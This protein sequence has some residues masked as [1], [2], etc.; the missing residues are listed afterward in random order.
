MKRVDVNSSTNIISYL[1]GEEVVGM[2][3]ETKTN[4]TELRVEKITKRRGDKLYAKWKILI[5][6]MSL[7]PEP[8]TTCKNKIKNLKNTTSEFAKKTKLA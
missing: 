3:Y 7:F 8:Y 1:S 6:K 2:F 4:Q 5:Y